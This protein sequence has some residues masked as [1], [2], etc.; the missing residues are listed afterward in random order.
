[1]EDQTTFTAMSPAPKPIFSRTE[2]LGVFITIFADGSE[3]L[4]GSGVPDHTRG[5]G[6]I[7]SGNGLLDQN[8]L[9][10]VEDLFI[11]H[12][13]LHCIPFYLRDLQLLQTIIRRLISVEN[14]IVFPVK[15]IGAAAPPPGPIAVAPQHQAATAM[16]HAPA[17]LVHIKSS[18][19][20]RPPTHVPLGA[21]FTAAAQAPGNKQIVV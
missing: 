11:N 12:R 13:P 4:P 17:L 8:A 7:E 1:M 3:A 14:E 16:G 20:F 18:D 6:A 5:D 2:S 15:S 19:I 9:V 21:V 10:L